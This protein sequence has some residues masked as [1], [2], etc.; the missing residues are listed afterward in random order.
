MIE[1]KRRII[2]GKEILIIDDHCIISK[3][4][5]DDDDT[6]NAIQTLVKAHCN[7]NRDG[8][9]FRAQIKTTDK[10]EAKNALQTMQQVRNKLQLQFDKIQ[11]NNL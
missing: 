10:D 9:E 1:V 5:M 7:C 6:F 3:M 11:L 4:C 8:I 2:N